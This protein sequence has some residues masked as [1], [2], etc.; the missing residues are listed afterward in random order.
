MK[1]T[2]ISHETFPQYIE[3]L[4]ARG[5]K[6]SGQKIGRTLASVL[7]MLISSVMA[8][9]IVCMLFSTVNA[10]R[11]ILKEAF[12]RIPSFFIKA[13]KWGIGLFPA[14]WNVWICMV[15]L[16]LVIPVTG[17][18]AGLIFRF[19]P[20]KGGTVK[21]EGQTPEER[22]GSAFDL[23]N[24]MRGKYNAA[25]DCFGVGL[26]VTPIA[27]IV[28]AIGLPIVSLI[29]NSTGVQ[30][31]IVLITIL[32]MFLQ[33]FLLLVVFPCVLAFALFWLT[34]A[35]EWA[36]SLFYRSNVVKTAD[37]ALTAYKKL[38]EEEEKQ[39]QEDAKQAHIR[40]VAAV[41]DQAVD[42]LIAG[43]IA[44]ALKLIASVE[45]EAEYPN[46]IKGL[47]KLLGKKPD[48][49]TWCELAQMDAQKPEL[50]KLQA[51]KEQLKKESYQ[52]LETLAEEE[53]TRGKQ[54]MAKQEFLRAIPHMQVAKIVDYRD[55]VAL[56]ALAT[57]KGKRSSRD[58]QWIYD[59]L[60]H[61][62]DKGLE[63][64][65]MEVICLT[66]MDEIKQMLEYERREA[67]D[68]RQA[69]AAA[70]AAEEAYWLEE[71]RRAN[72]SCQYKQGDYC[73]RYTTIDNFPHKCYYLDN[74][75]DMY[76]CSDRNS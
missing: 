61:G 46:E 21:V 1:N 9:L 37:S 23:V 38:L 72:M 67:E 43:N 6:L 31:Y 48:T 35:Q 42:A 8:A 52:M 24:F 66:A 39:R 5:T 7:N 75:R 30:W 63:D 76:R 41:Q 65:E 20:F 32:I 14:G 70:K 57:M 2:P 25:T 27:A 17:L 62:I 16:L 47:A 55:G 22:V 4:E 36:T 69:V 13:G 74:P 26:Y 3:S 10:E 60:Q 33:M 51:F 56:H 58:Y 49:N 68:R 44:Q 18:A 29:R 54:L 64:A 34:M 50:P 71:G 15:I 40:E 28:A 19:I 45:D 73:C 11:M 53:Y 12:N 59:D